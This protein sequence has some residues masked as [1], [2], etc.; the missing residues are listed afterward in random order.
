[1]SP[2]EC[3]GVFWERGDLISPAEA[4]DGMQTKYLI[5]FKSF[6]LNS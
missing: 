6:S 3:V 1:M 5:H 4:A 2:Q